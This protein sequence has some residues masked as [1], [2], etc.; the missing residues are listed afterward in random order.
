MR[1]DEI[2]HSRTNLDI[3]LDSLLYEIS[4]LDTC[5]DSLLY[6][7]TQGVLVCYTLS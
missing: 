5:T 2:F 1:P 7:R 4:Y 3:C 6:Y